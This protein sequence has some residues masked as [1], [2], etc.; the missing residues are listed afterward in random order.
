[1][2]R[3]NLGNVYKSKTWAVQFARGRPVRKV[4]GGWKICRGRKKEGDI[5]AKRRKRKRIK[6]R[7]KTYK[8]KSS[9]K[10]ARKKGQSIYKVKGGWRISRRRKR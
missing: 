8:K 2:V 7:R 3:S 4:A 10:K 1:M 9:A 6:S 5:V